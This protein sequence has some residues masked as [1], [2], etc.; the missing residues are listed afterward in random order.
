MKGLERGRLQW[1]RSRL[2]EKINGGIKGS[3][4]GKLNHCVALQTFFFLFYFIRVLFLIVL[5]RLY[6]LWRTCRCS[7]PTLNWA[8]VWTTC[9]CWWITA[10]GMVLNH[11][12]CY[13]WSFYLDEPESELTVAG[14]RGESW[15]KFVKIGVCVKAWSFQINVWI[16]S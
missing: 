3:I 14:G 10:V 1:R 7:L 16:I 2:S 8:A 6:F 5:K 9:P 12:L 11:C 13:L 4:E 15:D